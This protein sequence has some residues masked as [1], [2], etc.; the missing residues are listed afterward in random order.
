MIDLIWG[1]HLFDAALVL[2][3]FI[4]RGSDIVIASSW[5]WVTEIVAIASHERIGKKPGLRR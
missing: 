4:V 5:S 3:V 2:I 1:A